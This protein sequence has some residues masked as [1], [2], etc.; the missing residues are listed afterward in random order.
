MQHLFSYLDTFFP[1]SS[2]VLIRDN[3]QLKLRIEHQESLFLEAADIKWNFSIVQCV[4][5]HAKMFSATYL[6]LHFIQIGHL[7]VTISVEACLFNLPFNKASRSE[8]SS[9]KNKTFRHKAFCPTH[10]L[11]MHLSK[12]CTGNMRV[13]KLFLWTCYQKRSWPL[14][15]ECWVRHG[16]L[17]SFGWP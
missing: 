15:M 7:S 13:L 4:L 1:I 17:K 12:T 8:S 9:K 11:S 14:G 2:A 3:R 6:T 5:G 16:S 10:P